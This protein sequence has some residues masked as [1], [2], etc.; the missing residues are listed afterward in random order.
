MY[1]YINKPIINV[2]PTI[3]IKSSDTIKIRNLDNIHQKGNINT[4]NHSGFI[5]K[6][7]FKNYSNDEDQVLCGTIINS[8]FDYFPIL[9]TTDIAKLNELD[10]KFTKYLQVANDCIQYVLDYMSRYKWSFDPIERFVWIY[11]ILACEFEPRAIKYIIKSK[12]FNKNTLSLKNTYGRTFWYYCLLNPINVLKEIFD[13]GLISEQLVCAQD[14][15]NAISTIMYI[16]FD[17]PK[18]EYIVD[19]IPKLKDFFNTKYYQNLN[20]FNFSCYHY[21]DMAT[22]LLEKQ[23]INKSTFCDLYEGNFTCLM[24]ALLKNPGLFCNLIKHEYCTSELFTYRHIKYGNILDI[25][26]NNKVDCIINIIESEYFD[27]NMLY[28]NKNDNCALIKLICAKN[29][30]LLAIMKVLF[31]KQHIDMKL[32]DE[33]G[34]NIY[35]E[36][37]VHNPEC[38]KYMLLEQK[39]YIQNN[40]LNETIIYFANSDQEMIKILLDT[41]VISKEVLFNNIHEFT[42][43]SIMLN[44]KNINIDVLTYIIKTYC[45]IDE[46]C[47]YSSFGKTNKTNIYYNIIKNIPELALDILENSCVFLEDNLI[48]EFNNNVPMY[49]LILN[50]INNQQFI[51]TLLKSEYFKQ[52]YLT[53]RLQTGENLLLNLINNNNDNFKLLINETKLDPLILDNNNNNILIS[54][55]KS[56]LDYDVYCQLINSSDDNM[57]FQQNAHGNNALIIASSKSLKY[58]LPIINHKLFTKDMFDV[59]NN[60]GETCLITACKKGDLEMVKYLCDNKYMTIKLFNKLDVYSKSA[61]YYAFQY[62]DMFR[63]IINHQLCDNNIFLDQINKCVNNYCNIYDNLKTILLSKQMTSK[64]YYMYVYYLKNHMFNIMFE[65]NN[66]RPYIDYNIITHDL[67]QLT[68][69]KKRNIIMDAIINDNMD[70]YNKILNLNIITNDILKMQD[71]KGRTILHLLIIYYE[72]DEFADFFDKYVDSDELLLITDINGNTCLHTAIKLK[73]MLIFNA[74][75][76]SKY[77]TE[78]LLSCIDNH[79]M[80]ILH[81]VYSDFKLVNEIL[82]KSKNAMNLLG[83]FNTHKINPFMAICG[84]H[85]EQQIVCNILQLDSLNNKIIIDEQNNLCGLCDIIGLYPKSQILKYILESDKINLTDHI[86]KNFNGTN[87]LSYTIK[88]RNVPALMC[89]LESKYN[90]TESFDIFDDIFDVMLENGLD[91][92]AIIF[93]SK[94]FSKTKLLVDKQYITKFMI[95][96]IKQSDHNFLDYMCM[97]GYYNADYLKIVDKNNENIL[98]QDLEIFGTLF[99]DKIYLDSEI[100]LN[101]NK[102]GL[103]CLQYYCLNNTKLFSTLLNSVLCTKDLVF[104]KDISGNTI[105]HNAILNNITANIAVITNSLYCNKEMLLIQNNYKEN[106]LMLL[107]RNK[108]KITQNIIDMIDND[109]VGQCDYNNNNLLMYAIKYNN[110]IVIN[111]IIKIGYLTEETIVFANLKHD[112]VITYSARYNS[113]MIKKIIDL[114]LLTNEML[115]YGLGG[116][117]VLA[118]CCLYQPTALGY[119]LGW[120][121]INVGLIN[122]IDGNKYNILQLACLQ[123]KKS[124]KIILDCKHDVLSLFDGGEIEPA[125]FLAT[126]YNP[127]ALKYILDSK[128]CT[129]Q[130]FEMVYNNN[131]IIDEGFNNQPKSL[132]Y[133]IQ[134]KFATEKFLLRENF[135]GWSLIT[136]LKTIYLNI[137][138]LSDIMDNELLS[139]DN[140]TTDDE[141]LQCEI[142]CIFKYKVCFNKCGHRTCI[143]CAFKIDTCHNCRKPIE[144]KIIMY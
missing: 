131:T 27:K 17:I 109:M 132:K 111:A 38:L 140:E 116:K 86:N 46:Y 100:L 51:S 81:Y 93:V 13:L 79:K 31:N 11:L 66:V 84:L 96:L 55:L 138:S 142:C 35:Y 102:M 118:I 134:S 21:S 89:L 75:L 144:N 56:I 1:S 85:S 139:Y 123:N 37:A 9:E 112:N 19:K 2:K 30:N 108:K 41:L 5:I 58:V 20:I 42:V 97:N 53:Y 63:Y 126:M 67:L 33:L 133:I 103:T 121:K 64:L 82:H 113:G 87:I 22:H 54:F 120:D 36:L 99:N 125:I 74:I 15:E 119:I 136:T 104:S 4:V 90:F 23:Y 32:I 124:V 29:K 16:T 44:S 25:A 39:D 76:N 71:Y 14:T 143:G 83:Q 18:L 60:F 40:K 141:I 101:K 98:Y 69:K 129:K 10:T 110:V 94:Y 72:I 48:M 12:H 107:I 78:K 115:D 106:C 49:F 91:I 7:E 117:S 128:Y 130:M 88:T 47:K 70:V 45:D 24:I 92:F 65:H 28:E 52:E 127:E 105:L 26:V 34:G 3:T 50:T 61:I 6:K 62:N 43:L 80:N 122:I 95:K 68:N 73:D 137:N 57:L 77:C 135:K 8:L 59:V 114:G